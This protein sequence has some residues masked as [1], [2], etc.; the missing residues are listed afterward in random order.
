VGFG[1]F[2]TAF[3]LRGA[4]LWTAW[5]SPFVRIP[6]V[7]SLAYHERA[8]EIL[9][10]SW[11]GEGV[12]YQD[13]LYPYWLAGLYALFG[14]GSP[15]VLLTQSLLDSVSVV[16]VWLIA[17][18]VFGD[19]VALL[20]GLFA[21]LYEVM[22]Y[23]D[24]LLLKAPL[25]LFLISLALA[26]LVRADAGSKLAAWLGAGFAFGLATLTR[27]NYLAFAPFV[28]LWPFIAMPGAGR[29]RAAAAGLAAAG[30]ALA[31]LPVTARNWA[32][33]GDFV[34]ITS[35]AGQNFYIG[36]HRGNSTGEYEAP[37]FV[38]AHPFRE[39]A[40]FRAEG[41]RR[42]GRPLAPGEL[43]SFWFREALAE[44]RADPAHFARHT[45]KK[46]RVF[47]NDYEVPDN[48]SYTFFAERVSPILRLPFPT[49]GALLPLAFV[50]AAFARRNRRALLLAT[51]A[52]VYAATVI[53][54][55][56][57]SRYRIPVLPSVQ[58]LAAAGAVG[59]AQRLQRREWR[60]VLPA[61]L[62][63]ALAWPAVYQEVSPRRFA[64]V[65]GNVAVALERQAEL[66]HSRALAAGA[67]GD[68]S[69]AAEA[70]AEARALWD[71]SESEYRK[72][73]EL[74]PQHRPSQRA[75]R[76]ALTE[77]AAAALEVGDPEDARARAR[78]L[79]AR[80]PRHAEGFALLA[81]AELDL[82]D[83]EAARRALSRALVLE[84]RNPRGR[85]LRPRLRAAEAE[86]PPGAAPG[87]GAP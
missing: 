69:A 51:F 1:L 84:P 19:G 58:V 24:L 2:A 11:L 44:I 67:A 22:F 73:L 85:S 45:W 43:S 61:L 47:F 37:D 40:D 39:Q 64:R 34:L 72:A 87:S 57:M 35:Q 49:F 54:F 8:L 74:R 15:M 48:Q 60:G 55:F 66:A 6:L 76:D 23:Y 83:P 81:E 86:T 38:V 31:I 27:G 70:H 26:L 16:L 65:H 52:L 62:F 29:R 41:E 79:T 9:A 50:G 46:V 20:A 30:M 71:R 4:T 28:V 68:D 12:F 63:L 80:F 5:Q 33:S 82:G 21:C 59:L 32:V 10:G 25:S 77:A 14:P 3:A 42:A 75:L 56:N 78:A 36:N 17:R 18:R 13:P 7:D 53:A